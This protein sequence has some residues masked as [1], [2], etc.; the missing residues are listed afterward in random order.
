MRRK[1]TNMKILIEFHANGTATFW[2]QRGDDA[3]YHGRVSQMK[4]G[5]LLRNKN[6]RELSTGMGYDRARQV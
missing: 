5:F 6:W 4:N 1:N 3:Y 2:W